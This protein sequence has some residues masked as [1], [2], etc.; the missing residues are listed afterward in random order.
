M[1]TVKYFANLKQ[2]AGKDEDQFDINEGTTLEQL[3]DFI[4][5]SVPQLGNMVR[6]KKVMISLN[7]DVVPLDTVVK[8][9]D[10]IALLPPFSGGI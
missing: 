2:M 4:E 7:Y 6:D 10:E 9:G 1:V 5:Q 8:D 3:S